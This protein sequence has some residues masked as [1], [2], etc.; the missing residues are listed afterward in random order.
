MAFTFVDDTQILE[1]SLDGRELLLVN[2]NE[3]F[4]QFL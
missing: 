2:N 1:H 3:F 4:N